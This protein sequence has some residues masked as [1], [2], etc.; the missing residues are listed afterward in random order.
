MGKITVRREVYTEGNIEDVYFLGKNIDISSNIS[1]IAVDVEKIGKNKF[2]ISKSGLEFRYELLEAQLDNKEVMIS[3]SSELRH[4]K[5]LPS[6]FNYVKITG[7]HKAEGVLLSG[8]AI[9]NVGILGSFFVNVVFRSTLDDLGDSFWKGV[10][11]SVETFNED[12]VKS[13]SQVTDEQWK[14]IKDYLSKSRIRQKEKK[15][16]TLTFTPV[17][18]SS[19]IRLATPVKQ[20]VKKGEITS[21]DINK[22]F[23]NSFNNL[24]DLATKIG[25]GKGETNQNYNS[26]IDFY[27]KMVKLGSKLYSDYLPQEVRANLTSTLDYPED[28]Y[29]AIEAEGRD[30]NLPWEFLHDGN[31]FLCLLTPIIRVPSVPKKS[32]TNF[33]LKKV[34]IFAPHKYEKRQNLPKVLEESKAIYNMLSKESELEPVLIKGKKATKENLLNRLKTDEF[35]CLHFSGHSEYHP[36]APQTSFLRTSGGGRIRVDK[37]AL[38]FSKGSPFELVFLN[39]CLSGKGSIDDATGLAASFVKNGV[40]TAVGNQF[41]ISD[42]SAAELAKS[43]YQNLLKNHD[44]GEALRKARLRVGQISNWD[45]PAWAAPVLYT[46]VQKYNT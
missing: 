39:S 18:N 21:K 27:S 24:V 46:D 9:F 40:P 35:S 22:E 7:K 16:A 33:S 10:R 12:P 17:N 43:F 44:Y 5:F 34:L 41:I 8:K 42:K 15:Y 2:L 31:D 23:S 36:N 30:S 13:K 20:K 25:R 1:G 19:Y 32:Q 28:I 6:L 11:K 29:I 4:P 37:L 45:D 26:E 14:R 38:N 3:Y